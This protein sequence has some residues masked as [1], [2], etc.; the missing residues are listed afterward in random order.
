MRNFNLILHPDAL[1][2]VPFVSFYAMHVAGQ[3]CTA[4]HCQI[5]LNCSIFVCSRAE[6]SEAVKNFKDGIAKFTSMQVFV[7]KKQ[8]QFNVYKFIF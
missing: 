8:L 1:P 3:R 6:H 5:I 7:L 2:N 4:L